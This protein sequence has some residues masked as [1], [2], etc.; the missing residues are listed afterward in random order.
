M[1]VLFATDYPHLPENTG[2]LEVNTHEL[3]LALSASAGHP[4]S[5]TAPSGTAPSGTAPEVATSGHTVAVLAALRGRGLTGALARSKLRF[6]L[7]AG[8]AVDRGLGYPVLRAW[9]P[10]EALG[11]AMEWFRPDVVVV[12]SWRFGMVAEALRRGVASV[13]YSHSAQSALEGVDAGL[14]AHCVLVANS[15]FNA[16]FQG[17]AIGARFEVLHPL[18]NPHRY[19]CDGPRDHVVQVG[20]S[21]QKGAAVTLAVARQRPDIRFLV[22]QNWEGVGRRPADEALHREAAALANLRVIPPDHDVR[23]LYRRARLLLVPSQLPETW[24]RVVN[25]AQINAI[26]VV[27][28]NQGGLPEAVGGGGVILDWRAPAGAWVAEV[29]RLW[30]EPVWHAEMARRA[31]A[32]AEADDIRSDALLDRFVTLLQDARARRLQ[33]AASD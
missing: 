27:A 20:L 17:G 2:G 3:C 19:L 5:G 12:Q 15:A 26:P 25:E 13:L 11:A 21:L 32:R 10:A 8:F 24:G 33:P 29:A 30:D 16:G 9:H 28:S 6:G 1:R 4:P 23:R 22:V 7:A 18:I 14:L 31:R